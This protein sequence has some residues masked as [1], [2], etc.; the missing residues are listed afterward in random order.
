MDSARIISK[1][2]VENRIA[3]CVNIIPGLESMYL[4][5]G[6]VR[7]DCESLLII[8]T[9]KDKYDAIESVIKS[10]HPYELPELI[11]LQIDKG[12]DKYLD[13]IAKSAQ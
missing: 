8:K 2:L 11:S 6:Q 7:N 4:W 1:A 10:L 9:T 12:L 3:A 5:E 13:W